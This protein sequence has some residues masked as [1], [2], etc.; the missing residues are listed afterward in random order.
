MTLSAPK[1]M[2]Q[3]EVRVLV[4][5]VIPKAVLSSAVFNCKAQLYLELEPV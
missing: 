1:F 5:W 4:S 2:Q 3:I